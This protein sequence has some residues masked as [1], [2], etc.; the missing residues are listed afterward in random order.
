M[1]K[2]IKT[3]Q[4]TDKEKFDDEV[5]LVLEY[6]CEL[7][8][9]SYEVIKKNDVV[10]YSQV[11]F[12]DDNNVMI[13]WFSNGQIWRI[14]IYLD[15]K[16]S[17]FD[18]KLDGEYKEWYENGNLKNRKYYEDGELRNLTNYYEN[19]E[20]ENVEYYSDGKKCGEH[21]G[22]HETGRLRFN[23]KYEDGELIFLKYFNNIDKNEYL[24]QDYLEIHYKDGEERYKKETKYYDRFETSRVWSSHLIRSIE[25]YRNG[26]RDGDWEEWN[27]NGKR[28]RVITYSNGK[29]ISEKYWNE[30]GWK[31]SETNYRIDDEIVEISYDFG[32]PIS[33]KRFKDGKPISSREWN[34]DGKKLSEKRF[35]DGKLIFSRE[36]N[37]DGS[38]KK[39]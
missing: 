27:K 4:S 37:E 5:N 11:I 2:K 10:I 24:D 18:Y 39:K 31:L 35:K 30:D 8:E 36:W 28:S 38:E 17:S 13:D 33:E 29:I 19:G 22:N 34:K 20:T 9:G 15:G 16:G 21:Y 32:Y 6:G 12:F 3:I 25:I 1:S 23:E 26:K 7:V 14:G